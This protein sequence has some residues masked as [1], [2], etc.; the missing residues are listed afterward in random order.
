MSRVKLFRF[1]PLSTLIGDG[2]KG[3]IRTMSKT[4]IGSQPKKAPN[5]S[6]YPRKPYRNN[7]TVEAKSALQMSHCTWPRGTK[8]S[9]SQTAQLNDL[10]YLICVYF[11]VEPQLGHVGNMLS[12][13]GS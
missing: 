11:K 13:L 2:Y 10:L 1:S 4:N 8:S 3:R 7:A 5:K 6:A 9:W 12:L